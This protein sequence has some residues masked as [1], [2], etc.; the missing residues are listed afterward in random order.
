MNGE[1]KKGLKGERG[2]RK[3][4]KPS[5]MTE[6]FAEEVSVSEMNTLQLHSNFFAA[7]FSCF[8]IFLLCVKQ[9][10]RSEV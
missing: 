1:Q 4:E 2:E 6:C 7:L 8:D 9:K 5:R 3:K 10:M